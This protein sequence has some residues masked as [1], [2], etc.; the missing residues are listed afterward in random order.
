MSACVYP[1]FGY[2]ALAANELEL[3]QQKLVVHESVVSAAVHAI[4]CNLGRDSGISQGLRYSFE[5]VRG[6]I[7]YME[8]QRRNT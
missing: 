4:E 7:D 3:L 8:Q 1:Q 5:E 2:A 6:A